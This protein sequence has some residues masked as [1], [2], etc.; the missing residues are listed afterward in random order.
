[1]PYSEGCNRMIQNNTAALIT[2][3]E[4]F[5]KAMGWKVRGKME[6]GELFPELTEEER[7]V[8]EV[9]RQTNDLQL[10]MLSVRTNIPVGQLSGLL[11]QLEMKGIVKAYAGGNY[12]LVN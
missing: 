7:A 11:F 12:H 6:E 4:D 8:V 10:N 2:S 3:A 9:L 1:M 5:M